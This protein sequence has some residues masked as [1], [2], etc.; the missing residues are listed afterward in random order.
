MTAINGLIFIIASVGL[1]A[2]FWPRAGRP[3]IRDRSSLLRDMIPLA[4]V[5]GL[6]LRVTMLFSVFAHQEPST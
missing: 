2:Y 5:S 4:A 6:A 3:A 1:F